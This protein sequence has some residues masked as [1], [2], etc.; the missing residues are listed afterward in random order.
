M[1][2]DLSERVDKAFAIDKLMKWLMFPGEGERDEV[3]SLV[4]AHD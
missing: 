2:R 4:D 3:P 1:L